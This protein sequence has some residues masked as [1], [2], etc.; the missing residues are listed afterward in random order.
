MYCP[1]LGCCGGHLNA[2]GTLLR[3]DADGALG[4]GLWKGTPLHAAAAEGFLP[5]I[6]MLLD[7]GCYWG[8][9]DDQ[10]ATPSML[11]LICGNTDIARAIREHASKLGMDYSKMKTQTYSP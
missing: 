11:A 3:N 4:G 2:V 1:A 5:V 9:V 7:S 6:R 8:E 10:G